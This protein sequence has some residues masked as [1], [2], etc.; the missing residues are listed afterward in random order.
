M[1][2]FGKKLIFQILVILSCPGYLAHKRTPNH[3]YYFA[4]KINQ[5]YVIEKSQ[6]EALDVEL[7]HFLCFVKGKI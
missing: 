1:V 5:H 2:C 7:L 6:K 3:A 4:N